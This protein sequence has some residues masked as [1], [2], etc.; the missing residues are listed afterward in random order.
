MV[1]TNNIRMENKGQAQ[2]VIIIIIILL[3]LVAMGAIP[4]WEEKPHIKINN[5]SKSKLE[6]REDAA[7]INLTLINPQ[8]E[9]TNVN[10]VLEYDPNALQVN[11]LSKQVDLGMVIPQYLYAKEKR[12]IKLGVG[13][14]GRNIDE[15]RTLTI[16]LCEKN[17]CLNE[18]D[19]NNY[20]DKEVITFSLD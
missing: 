14:I 5:I 2:I 18:G 20:L 7:T 16:Y 8:S 6:Y 3:V 12:E 15:E 13:Q 9:A 19:L 1:K 11:H 10:W 4:W 17:K